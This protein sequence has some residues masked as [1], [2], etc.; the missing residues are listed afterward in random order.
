MRPGA[1][2]RAGSDHGRRPRHRDLLRSH[3][4]HPALAVRCAVP[5]ERAAGRHH[6]E[7]IDGHLRQGLRRAGRRR[8]SGRVDRDVPE[9]H[10]AGDP[11]GRGVPVRWPDRRTVD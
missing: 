5:A 8:G 9:E 10:R 3:R 11:A 7:G 4:S 2:G 1:D 6:P